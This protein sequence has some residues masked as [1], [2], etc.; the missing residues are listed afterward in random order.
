M[1]MFCGFPQ[2]GLVFSGSAR[3]RDST[4]QDGCG[5]LGRGRF[6]KKG[7][8]KM[9]VGKVPR[10]FCCASADRLQN[11]GHF[12][13]IFCRIAPVLQTKPNAGIWPVMEAHDIDS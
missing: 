2:T 9:R 1:N 4:I 13:D 5:G 8:G 12:C 10:N 7:R 3:A 6:R 11:L